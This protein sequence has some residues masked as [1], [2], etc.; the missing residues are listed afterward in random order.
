MLGMFCCCLVL[1]LALGTKH[2]AT[3]N[4]VLSDTLALGCGF[5][6]CYFQCCF[7]VSVLFSFPNKNVDRIECEEADPSTMKGIQHCTS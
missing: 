7:C 6:F 1:I 3:K 4:E 5:V 2:L